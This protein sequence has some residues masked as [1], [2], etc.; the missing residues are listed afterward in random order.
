[1]DRW[2]DKALLI[3]FGLLDPAIPEGLTSYLSQYIPLL[4]KAIF[5]GFLLLAT[6]VLTESYTAKTRDVTFVFTTL[7]PNKQPHLL[8]DLL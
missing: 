8:C 1:M 7:H 5:F 3:T 2:K 4:L 6:K